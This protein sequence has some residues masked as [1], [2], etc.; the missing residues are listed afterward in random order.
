[1]EQMKVKIARDDVEITSKDEED[2]DDEITSKDDED[3][4]DHEDDEDNED[5]E[6]HDNHNGEI[7]SENDEDNE[8]NEDD[9]V[10]AFNNEMEGGVPGA[11]H[12][13]W[14]KELHI[15]N[16]TPPIDA[17]SSKRRRLISS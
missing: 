17:T 9:D 6:D 13:T 1:M 11:P 16:Q 5:D 15:L 12:T 3:D 10:G 8:D 4:K 14:I 2:H 7:T